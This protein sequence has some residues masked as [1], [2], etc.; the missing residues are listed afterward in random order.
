M[1]HNS[2][3]KVESYRKVL[4]EYRSAHK[5]LRKD[6]DFRAI[7]EVQM[8]HEDLATAYKALSQEDL[9]QLLADEH[10]D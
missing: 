4:A 7:L 8:I 6:S 1:S 2:S 10:I 5:K 3:R 9:T